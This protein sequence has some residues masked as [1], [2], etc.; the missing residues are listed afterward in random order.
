MCIRDREEGHHDDHEV[1]RNVFCVKCDAPVRGVLCQNVVGMPMHWLCLRSD[2]GE[3]AR[4]GFSA[5]QLKRIRREEREAWPEG[6]WRCRDQSGKPVRRG[7]WY[8]IGHARARSLLRLL[9]SR[10]LCVRRSVP[11]VTYEDYCQPCHDF[12]EHQVRVS[13]YSKSEAG[14][15]QGCCA[16]ETKGHECSAS[17]SDVMPPGRVGV[18]DATASS[19]VYRGG[20]HANKNSRFLQCEAPACRENVSVSQD[21]LAWE[22]YCL[23]HGL[24][25]SWGHLS[26]AREVCPATRFPGV[27]CAPPA[28]AASRHGSDELEDH[29]LERTQ[30]RLRRQMRVRRGF[31]ASQDGFCLQH[32]VLRCCDVPMFRRMRARF[33]VSCRGSGASGLCKGFNEAANFVAVQEG[34]AQEGVF[35]WVVR[36]ASV[37]GLSLIHI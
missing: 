4:W 8:G 6:A 37:A 5:R 27:L 11:V 33:L 3:S 28:V 30:R 1:E 22:A 36:G 17:L 32:A 31:N 26:L 35:V 23:E 21:S 15:D 25:Y 10:G 13:Q 20:P 12:G 7:L 14:C 9:K 16:Q 29:V 24:E 34:L 2:E 19:L 18:S